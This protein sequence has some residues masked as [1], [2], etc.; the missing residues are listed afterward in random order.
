MPL[1]QTI[2]ALGHWLLQQPERVLQ[3]FVL[4]PFLMVSTASRLRR[5]RCCAC[6]VRGQLCCAW[7]TVT[8]HITGAG[9]ARCAGH[10]GGRVQPVAPA[11][12]GHGAGHPGRRPRTR[13]DGRQQR[14]HADS[15]PPARVVRQPGLCARLVGH[16]SA[17]ALLDA[18]LS[19]LLHADDL[20]VLRDQVH[21]VL[22]SDTCS[23]H[24]W[25]ARLL[26]ATARAASGEVSSHRLNFHGRHAVWTTFA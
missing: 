16:E 9:R 1:C 2:P 21:A 7:R 5:W 13:A 23:E 25:Q 22:S 20:P 10:P 19:T 3:V 8:V 24:R 15:R 14:R 18:P 4:S 26:R 6:P 17:D 12:P 11:R